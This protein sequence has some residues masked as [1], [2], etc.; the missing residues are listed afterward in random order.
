MTFK[1]FVGVA[2]IAWITHAVIVRTNLRNTWY[3][4]AAVPV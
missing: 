3:D 1:D 2:L 4:P